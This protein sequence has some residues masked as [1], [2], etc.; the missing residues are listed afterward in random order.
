MEIKDKRFKSDI[1]YQDSTETI[2]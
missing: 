1:L 2:Q